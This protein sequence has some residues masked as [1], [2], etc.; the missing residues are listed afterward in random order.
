M[1]LNLTNSF[2][3]NEGISVLGFISNT[4][5]S[6]EYANVNFEWN[7][8]EIWEGFIPYQYRRTGLD[9]RSEKDLAEY[10][11]SIKHY[12]TKEESDKWIKEQRLFWKSE[13]TEANVTY[14]FFEAMLTLKW[15]STFPANN[16]PQRRIQDIKELGY[17]IATRLSNKQTERL[18]LPLPRGQKTGYES[19]TTQF[20]SRVIRLLKGINAFEGKT[21]NV[22]ALIPD[23]KFSEI[24]WDNDTKSENTMNM[25]DEEIVSKFQL[26]DN[27]RN[28]QKREICRN[29]Y[30]TN[31][32]GT[33]YGI[34]FFYKGCDNW[35]SQIPTKGKEAEIGCEG[36]PWY[37]IQ[38]WRDEL[39]KKLKNGN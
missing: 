16:N 9:I 21:T 31:K 30:Q 3:S 37:D 25:S 20:K 17:T 6:E 26:L 27:Q 28:L 8:K 33:I 4:K 38:K 19:F 36:C 1:D 35:D 29:C 34:D 22:N 2:F 14:P 32:R 7:N 12:F 15:T 10:L 18:L 11:I 23:H 24:R 13:K 39:N 5:A